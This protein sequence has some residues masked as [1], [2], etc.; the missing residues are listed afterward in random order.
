MTVR[1]G[2]LLVAAVLASVVAPSAVPAQETDSDSTLGLVLAGGGALGF[3]HVGA[4]LVL[5]EYGISPEIVVGTSMGGIAGALYAAGYSA[6]EILALTESIDWNGIFF[7]EINRRQATFD[8]RRTDRLSRGRLSFSDGRLQIRGGATAGQSIMELLDDLMRSVA[9]VEDFHTLPRSLSVVAADLVTGEQVVFRSGDVKNAVRASMAVPGA[10][11]PVFYDGRFLIDGGWVN[12]TPV[13]VARAD[14]AD[15]VIAVDLNLLNVGPEDLQDIPAILNQSSRIVRQVSIKENL[16]RADVVITPDL[17][18]FTPADF[19]AWEELVERGR[20]A[21]MDVLPELLEIAQET[22][23]HVVPA[24]LRPEADT[25]LQIRSVNIRVPED[26]SF[27]EEDEA[28]EWV[29][30]ALSEQKTTVAAVQ[31]AV[32]SLYDTGGFHSVTYDLVPVDGNQFDLDVYLLPRDSAASDLHVGAGVRTQL[33]ESSYVRSILYADFRTALAPP[34]VF[35]GQ[36]DRRPRFDAEA[37]ISD[38]ASARVGLS[39]PIVPSLRVRG[40]AYSLS[41]PIPFY[42]AATVRALYFQRSAGTDLGLQ[43]QPGQEWRFD[44]SG[45]GEWAWVDRI[46]GVSL[47]E[48]DG[49]FRVGIAGL[50]RHDNLD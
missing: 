17:A 10:F 6:R 35:G 11:T 28:V 31:Q 44:V 20:A 14:G 2:V 38:V 21:A 5:E 4:L 15:R 39:F 47:L 34:T 3:A 19:G 49:Q 18:G 32:Y 26:I 24:S 1:R 13:D 23:H 42:D 9:P 8:D 37:W 30:A 40:R 22:D 46:Q 29:E 7:D 12:N 27:A 45:F 25:S 36:L 50:A 33:F 16:A 43:F 48:N 41:T